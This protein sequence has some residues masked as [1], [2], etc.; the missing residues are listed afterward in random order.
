MY[1]SALT[2]LLTPNGDRLMTRIVAVNSYYFHIVLPREAMTL[3]EFDAAVGELPAHVEGVV[4]LLPGT[5]EVTL[6]TSPQDGLRS[7]LP[8]LNAFKSQY[9]KF[10]EEQKRK[11]KRR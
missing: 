7:F 4:R 3:E 6:K 11:G 8:H 10:F 5:S 2:K 1:R 9:A